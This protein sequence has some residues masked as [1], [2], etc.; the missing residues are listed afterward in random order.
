LTYFGT[1]NYDVELARGRIT[2]VT[3][4]N[5]FGRNQDIDTTEEDVWDAGGTYVW[6]S[7]AD[8]T[9]IVSSAAD[10][11][12][13]EIQ[14]LDTNWDQVV[15]T[16]TLTGTTSVALDTPLRR[17]FRLKN[18][19]GAAAAG[20]IQCGVGSTTTSF[21]AA[22]TR[23]QISLGFEQTLMAI[24]T[25]PAGKTGLL[26]RLWSNINKSNSS[27]GLDAIF[28]ARSEG[29]VFRVQNTSGLIAAGNSRDEKLYSPMPT[30]AEKTDLRISGIGSTNNFD[31]SAGFDLYIADN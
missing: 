19:S 11:F 4:V 17:V 10:T 26:K 13:V 6:S 15:Q 28:W 30:Y 16:K 18:I 9:D 23:A 7:S 20:V 25:I 8:I 1:T 2:D 3:E 31:V 14:G 12:E 22:N 29:G 24:Y 5:K 27:G 21:S